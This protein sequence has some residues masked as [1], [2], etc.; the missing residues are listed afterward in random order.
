MQAVIEKK[1]VP[2]N[3][4]RLYFPPLSKKQILQSLEEVEQEYQRGEYYD[5]DV[6]IK[7]FRAR[8]GI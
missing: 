3:N 5:A 1:T 8:C 6:V 7:D 2:K 4:Q